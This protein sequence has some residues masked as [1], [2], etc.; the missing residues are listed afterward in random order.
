MRCTNNLRLRLRSLLHRSQVERELD[1]ELQFHL[2]QQIEENRAA[3]MSRE[4]AQRAAWRMF[5]N[6]ASLK[7]QARDTWGISF[8]E[9]LWQ[10]LRYGVRTL[11]QSP[12]FTAVAVLSLALGIGA[13]TAIFSVVNTVLLRPPPLE[14]PD[15]V[16]NLQRVIIADG[17]TRP[18]AE[19]VTSVWREDAQALEFASF[20]YAYGRRE[21]YLVEGVP[22]EL[23]ARI[24]GLDLF[25]VL[26]VNPILGRHFSAPARQ[27]GGYIIS[28]DL[29]QRQFGGDPDVIGRGISN[30]DWGSRLIVG[31][32]PAGFWFSKGAQRTDFW[33][34]DDRWVG[35]EIPIARLKRGVTV[36]QAQA[37][38][39][40][41]AENAGNPQLYAKQPTRHEVRTVNQDAAGAYA[42]PLKLLL[43]AVGFILLIG[44]V[45]VA[46]LLLARATRRHKE[47]STRAALGAPPL[48]LFRQLITESTLLAGMGGVAGTLVAY[49]GI[50]LFV[51]LAP[52]WYGRPEDYSIDGPVLA[53]TLGIAFL[54][55]ILFGLVPALQS[56]KPDLTVALKD[57]ARTAT[58]DPRRRLQRLLAIAEVAISLTLLIGAALMINSFTRF[59]TTDRG[60]SQEG[61]LTMRLQLRGPVYQ[62][63]GADG[64]SGMPK[65]ETAAFYRRLLERVEALPGVL[66]VGMNPDVMPGF[67]GGSFRIIG[68]AEP[69]SADEWRADYNEVN[70]DV[71][72]TMQVPLVRGRLFTSQDTEHAPRVAIINQKF[73]DQFFPNE[74]PI[75]QMLETP[76][77]FPTPIEDPREIVGIVGDVISHVKTGAQPHVFVPYRQ[78]THTTGRYSLNQGLIIRTTTDPMSL[79]QPVRDVVSALDPTLAVLDVETMETR[80]KI[81]LQ[82][83]RQRFYVRLLSVFAGLALF[84]AAVGLFGVISYSVAQRTREF[85]LRMALGAQRTDILRSVLK[86]GLALSLVGVGIGVLA[87]LGLTKL[88]ENQLYEVT[89]TDPATFTAACV[90]LV[91]VVL[92]AAYI[93]GRRAASVDPMVAIR[94]E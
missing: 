21:V 61:L 29:W 82:D 52:H 13:N 89:A 56:S 71:F 35:Y 1:S 73:A 14:E 23:K 79:A 59:V 84:L 53:Y 86:E 87:S 51:L 7:E 70:A 76:A 34:A 85:G 38:I 48:R 94:H 43:G 88:I 40:V 15:R 11:A 47:I 58:R 46:I 63:A 78:Y 54:T 57:G 69:V 28:H 77:S 62:E 24:V 41:I 42:G 74:D 75:G 19:A 16:V 22:Q 3:G 72:R 9:T 10:D 27:G 32:M 93:P 8:V 17:R 80:L 12:G 37:E 26:G 25:R 4:E 31:V 45:N 50:R 92:L 91:G 20:A 65:P 30:L 60:F 44:C 36:E 55:A 83:Q 66:S 6:V 90:V 33:Y 18:P 81:V 5:G 39:N 64:S 67:T 2:E 49:A 68:R